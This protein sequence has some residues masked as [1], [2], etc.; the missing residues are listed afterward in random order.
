MD[1]EK[2]RVLVDGNQPL[3]DILSKT[4]V[5]STLSIMI[6]D[7]LVQATTPVPAADQPPHT[8]EGHLQAIAKLV[9]WS[10]RPW[11]AGIKVGYYGFNAGIQSRATNEYVADPFC[12]V[13]RQTKKLDYEARVVLLIEELKRRSV[14]EPSVSVA[15]LLDQWHIPTEEPL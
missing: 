14:Q 8:I 15:E 3:Q 10:K 7:L 1:Y 5:G 6:A 11:A 4:T 12:H 2:A 9:D 13:P